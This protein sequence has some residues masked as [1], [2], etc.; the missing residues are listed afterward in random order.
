[1]FLGMAYRFNSSIVLGI[2]GDQPGDENNVDELPI[3][4]YVPRRGHSGFDQTDS[5]QGPS[6]FV[7]AKA[8]RPLAYPAW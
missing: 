3:L 5:P 1:M 4:A 7:R 2:S 8:L 6:T